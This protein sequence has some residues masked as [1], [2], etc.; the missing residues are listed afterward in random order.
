VVAASAVVSGHPARGDTPGTNAT[1]RA[2][3]A[4]FEAS[5][6]SPADVSLAEVHDPTA[7][8]ELLDLEDL[9]LAG[10][11]EAIALVE[12]GDTSLG[13][14][15]PVNVSGGLISRGHPVGATGLAQIVELSRQL[16]DRAGP[17]QV[18]SA[19]VGLAQMAGGVLGDDSAVAVVHLLHS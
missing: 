17:S 12:R 8:Q 7:P 6:I 18:P 14:R 19:R 2:A 13:G 3:R 11:G 5:G 9:G 4:A 15:L 10:R 16:M 1:A